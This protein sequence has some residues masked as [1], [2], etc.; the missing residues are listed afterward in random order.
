MGSTQSCNLRKRQE[1]VY[2][3]SRL[4]FAS[5]YGGELNH[6]AH[7][8]PQGEEAQS[9][10]T[11]FSLNEKKSDLVF[12]L[13]SEMLWRALWVTEW[14]VQTSLFLREIDWRKVV[15]VVGGLPSAMW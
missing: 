4:E 11:P 8:L 15:V 12:I 5:R 3:G 13:K 14:C 7:P 6:R 1:D 9:H 10:K 2:S